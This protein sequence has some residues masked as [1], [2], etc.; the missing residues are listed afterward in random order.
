MDGIKM[1]LSLFF[2]FL[3]EAEHYLSDSLAS[4]MDNFVPRRTVI[5]IFDES[6]HSIA[7]KTVAVNLL[8]ADAFVQEHSDQ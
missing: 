1:V 8:L 4:Q 5:F 3:Q 7:T 2:L 6:C